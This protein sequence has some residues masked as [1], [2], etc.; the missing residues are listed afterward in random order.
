MTYY[1]AFLNLEDRKVLLFGGGTVALRKARSLVKTGACIAAISKK[2]SDPFLKFARKQKIK[3]T[4]S[5]AFP[6]VLHNVVLVVAATSD[7]R[8]NQKVY[9]RCNRENIFVNV[10]DDPKHSTFIVPSLLQRGPLQIA[11]STG[12]K[13]PFLAKLIRKKLKRQF[14]GEYRHIVEWLGKEREKVKRM[15]KEQKARQRYLQ[16]LVEKKLSM[17][18]HTK[19]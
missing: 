5:S 19:K 7:P 15:I 17:F 13:S 9:E 12:G 4:R 1:P 10:V 3:L 2:F 18:E 11:V 8:F 6:K 16:K 14:S